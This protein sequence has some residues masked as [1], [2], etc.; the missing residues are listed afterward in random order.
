GMLITNDA[1]IYQRAVAF[2]HYERHSSALEDPDLRCFAGLPLGGH[3]YRMHQLS[4]AVGRVQLRYY[5]ERLEE[6]QRAMNHFWD[7]LEGVPGLRAHRPAA[8]SGGTMGG[9]DN[10]MG[11]YVNGELG[12]MD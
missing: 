8:G 6:I 2:G 7:L 3:K 12:G 5:R 9:W 1:L 11:L 10:P 4:S